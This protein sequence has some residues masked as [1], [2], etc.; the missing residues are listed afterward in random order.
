[1][2]LS[3]L[4]DA[5]KR[6]EAFP[7]HP[8]SIEVRHTHISA[9]Y[10]AD[11]LVYKVKKPVDFGFLNF[12]TLE[13]RKKYCEAEV[14]LNDRLAP[15]VYL[16]VVPITL[17]NGQ[18]VF[19]G[20]G[21][22]VEWAVKMRRLPDSATLAERLA[23]GLADSETFAS[24]G[25]RI[26]AFHDAVE[27]SPKI[28]AHGAFSVVEKNSSEN[29]TQSRFQE[30]VTVS[31]EV[32]DRLEALNRRE[33]DRLKPLI[34]ARSVSGRVKDVHGD[35]HLN[36]VYV[37]PE[38]RPPEDIAVLDCVEFN[39]SYRCSDVV[40]D[41]AFMCMD[42]QFRGRPDLS[43]VFADAYFEAGG[44]EEGR[45]LLPFYIAYRAAVRGKV[46]GMQAFAK[47]VPEEIRAGAAK[48]SRK[49]WL[50]A[51]GSLAAPVARPALV[52]TA[53]LPGSGKSRLAK[54][55]AQ[56][57]DFTLV[58]SDIVR[59]ELAGLNPTDSAKAEFGEGIYTP[60]WNDRTYDEC[61]RRAVELLF[62]G[63]RVI[64]DA[65]FREEG[66]RLHFLDLAAG[67]GVPALIFHRTASDEVVKERLGR[68]G[69]HSISDADWEINREA[70]RRWEVAGAESG[71]VTV[72]IP[73]L[74][75]KS[76][77]MNIALAALK[78]AGL[79]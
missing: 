46:E 7:H 28:A 22:P 20:A 75:N 3:S 4:L 54:D 29:F 9:V 15:S 70:Q 57:A 36:H 10:L 69:E 24:L 53:G 58:V 1:M 71:G 34:E 41:M 35:L 56:R 40:A 12:L 32:L 11:D 16:G 13:S 73:H 59:K 26:A 64:V 43:K 14:R 79:Y 31:G 55:L 50:L 47:E 33:L 5:L 77:P 27:T 66:R 62:K 65:S 45:R 18:P 68:R 49:H 72:N 39:D 21:E 8:G 38:K 44:D 25:R 67:L 17:E 76:E 48:S 19:E 74:E 78:K 30:G 60:E 52:L 63:R 37:F 61:A 23:A 2:D 51:L 6:P 42:L